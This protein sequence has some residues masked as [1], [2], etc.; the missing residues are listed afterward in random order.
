MK[1]S[2][3]IVKLL[4][5]NG[6]NINV[7]NKEGYTP[8][9]LVVKLKTKTDHTKDHTQI[10]N[11]DYEP[12]S[13]LDIIKHYLKSKNAISTFLVFKLFFIFKIFIN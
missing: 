4:I 11:Y 13:D 2:F 10:P 3:T 8:M 12:E 7:K 5:E 1:E 6:A 9:D